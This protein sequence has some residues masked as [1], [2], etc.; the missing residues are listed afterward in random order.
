MQDLGAF[1]N[2]SNFCHILTTFGSFFSHNFW[3]LLASFGN[4]CHVFAT[5]STFWQLGLLLTSFAAL[6][7]FGQILVSFWQLFATFNCQLFGHFLAILSNLEFWQLVAF[8]V[9]ISPCYQA[10]LPS[11]HIFRF[12]SYHFVIFSSCPLLIH[13]L[14]NLSTCQLAILSN[15]HLVNLSSCQL[16]I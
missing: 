13:Q 6:S 16:V 10:I 8:D 11:C 12:S 15:C 14:V 1:H 2:F 3:Q 9:T 7:I 5:F 4:F